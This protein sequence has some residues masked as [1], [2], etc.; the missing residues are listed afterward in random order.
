MTS[1]YQDSYQGII[2]AFN[3]LRVAN[4]EDRRIYDPNYQGII[5]AITDLKKW[6]QAGDGEL[7]PN[8]EVV[9]NG[10][11]LEG[12]W[13]PPPDNG[14]LWF[15]TRQGRLFIWMDDGF[16]QTNGADGVPAFS[17]DPPTSEIPGSLWY[18]TNTGTLYIWDGSSWVALTAP[19]GF[20]TGSLML[21][22]PTTTALQVQ[23][24]RSCYFG[25]YARRLQPVDLPCL[26]ALEAD[27]KQTSRLNP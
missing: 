2:D 15:D 3:T 16:Y 24:K 22:N 23:V 17:D 4:G 25:Q 27:L 19:T 7:P 13:N 11:T 5:K 1:T 8:W 6:G 21:S 12:V 26:Q 20:S 9:D 10:G 14:T 18:N